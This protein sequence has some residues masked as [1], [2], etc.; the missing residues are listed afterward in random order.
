MADARK[1]RASVIPFTRP[2]IVDRIFDYIVEQ[3]P[4]IAGQHPDVKR[5]VRNEF[6][7]QFSYVRRR[8]IEENQG[9]AAEVARLF[10]GRSAT[11]VARIL[12]ISRA[13]VYR[14]LKQ[15]GSR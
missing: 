9:L 15:P 7:M 2:D 10:N 14:L 5:A 1:P 8:S 11:E 3:I 12:H 13:T 6:A 4:E